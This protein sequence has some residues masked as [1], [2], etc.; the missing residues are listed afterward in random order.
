VRPSA[1]FPMSTSC[2]RAGAAAAS[3][4]KLIF[5][6]LVGR[7]L[8]VGARLPADHRLRCRYAG[9]ADN[10]PTTAATSGIAVANRRNVRFFIA[11]LLL[12]LT[13]FAMGLGR[14]I[15]YPQNASSRAMAAPDQVVGCRRTGG[16]P[17]RD[18]RDD[19]LERVHC[20]VHL[21]RACASCAAYWRGRS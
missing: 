8:V 9:W 20:G 13:L 19:R 11:W 15:R 18:Q 6:L 12:A 14:Q 10:S 16:Q 5:D 21:F 7:Q 4:R 1:V 3:L 17:D 2:R